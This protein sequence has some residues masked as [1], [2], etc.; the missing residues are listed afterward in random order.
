ML[1]PRT[2]IVI[3]SGAGLS[4]ASGVPTFR[5]A[6]GL[7]HG[8]RVEDVASPRAW[9]A[10]RPMVRDF[11]DGRRISCAA[12]LPNPGHE[13]L[14]RLQHAIGPSRCTL[15]T[16]NVDGLIQKAG[17]E[18][19]LEMHGS[20]W[21]LKCEA[22][23]DHV[24]VG[25]FGPQDPE[26]RCGACGS[27]LRPDV[28]WFGEMPYYMEVIQEA[29]YAC[30]IFVSVG[31]S[32]VVYPAAGLSQIAKAGGARTLEVNP[33]PSGGAFDEVIEE[34]SETALPRM[35]LDWIDETPA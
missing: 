28:V 30:D 10:D 4:K 9:F 22:D 31:T 8:H 12:V 35:V 6:D 18:H 24:C 33:Q 14:A 26:R 32:G 7:W 1:D 34:G 13:A 20:L 5:D 19:V 29:V 3:L 17:A 15:I 16:Q 2:K 23:D 21:R 25:C 27:L 11:Y